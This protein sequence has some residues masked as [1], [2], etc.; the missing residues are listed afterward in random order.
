MTRPVLALMAMSKTSL[1]MRGE[2]SVVKCAISLSA[3]PFSSTCVNGDG[4]DGDAAE[5][6][7][8]QSAAVVA[9]HLYLFEGEAAGGEVVG[10][11]DDERT[12]VG[13][14]P[15]V[16]VEVFLDAVELVGRVGRPVL[17]DDGTPEVSFIVAAVLDGSVVVEHED[18]S[19]R[20]APAVDPQS[21]FT[22]GID[23]VEGGG[24]LNFGAWNAC[25]RTALQS[26]AQ[27]GVCP[28]LC[29]VEHPEVAFVVEAQSVGV[30]E[31]LG[32][33]VVGQNGLQWT[34]F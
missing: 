13:T 31:V 2:L 3:E 14:N 34:V 32:I 27:C 33:G 29:A 30:G 24:A 21:S 8:G 11:G 16:S 23:D 25:P 15:D 12:L 17:V 20:H 7:V 5:Q 28:S 4:G 22:V 6:I 10:F 1:A 26:H 18:A 19:L 9:R